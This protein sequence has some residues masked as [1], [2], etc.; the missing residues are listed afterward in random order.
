MSLSPTLDTQDCSKRAL[1]R[2]REKVQLIPSLACCRFEREV[3]TEASW[4]CLHINRA[5]LP[6]IWGR[7][8]LGAFLVPAGHECI[9][10]TGKFKPLLLFQWIERHALSPAVSKEKEKKKSA[11]SYLYTSYLCLRQCSCYELVYTRGLASMAFH[12][13]ISVVVAFLSLTLRSVADGMLKP[14]LINCILYFPSKPFPRK[15]GLA[16]E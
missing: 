9:T 15:V 10:R 11:C 6:R 14:T 13:Q 8:E 5:K 3:K 4:F 16:S 2:N 12:S 7:A 1:S